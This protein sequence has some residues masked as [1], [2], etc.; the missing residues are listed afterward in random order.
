MPD[1]TTYRFKQDYRNSVNVLSEWF[2]LWDVPK[3]L[4]LTREADMENYELTE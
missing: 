1:L 4:K 2:V 3:V